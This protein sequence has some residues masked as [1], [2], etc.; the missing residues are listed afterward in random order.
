MLEAL[1]AGRRTLERIYMTREAKGGE[2]T[3]ILELAAARRIPVKRLDRR[4]MEAV[5]GRAKHQGIVAEAAPYGYM[6]PEAILA[7]AMRRTM[8]PLLL[9]VD[10]L[11][12]PGNLGAIIR[13]AE[14]AGADGL[15]VPKHRAVG[16]TDAVARASAGALEHLSVGQATNI[17]RLLEEAK[18]RG[19]WV[20]GG[21]PHGHKNLYDVD[22]TVPLVLVIGGEHRGLRP[23]VRQNCDILAAIPMG[24]K[25]GSLNAAVAAGIFLFEVV[26]QRVGKHGPSRP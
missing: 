10:G 25:V 13:T 6:D 2:V 26:R 22:L 15:I 14:A 16:V 11:E 9:V 7:E 17:P 5:V 24:G 21:E 19:F 20:V 23:L 3:A 18:T 12:D 8:P 1:R 4:G